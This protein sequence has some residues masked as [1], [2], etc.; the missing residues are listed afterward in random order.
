MRSAVAERAGTESPSR[1]KVTTLSV[2]WFVPYCTTSWVRSN[3]SYQ[4]AHLTRAVA[5]RFDEQLGSSRAI[6]F[7]AIIAHRRPFF[8]GFRSGFLSSFFS[9]FTLTLP[10]ASSTVTLPA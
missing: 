8:S 4:V 7:L 6:V 10:S 5:A 9:S 2:A 1:S 3:S